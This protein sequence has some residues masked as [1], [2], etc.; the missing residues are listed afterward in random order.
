MTVSRPLRE[1]ILCAMIRINYGTAWDGDLELLKKFFP[2]W[3]YPKLS[4]DGLTH[5]IETF[6]PSVDDITHPG[7]I[8]DEPTLN[9]LNL[10]SKPEDS[11][12]L[13]EHTTDLPES[14]SQG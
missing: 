7:F 8:T 5:L 10:Q 12:S 2:D 4:A 11:I 6:S 1:Q 9:D 14:I 3:Y 13:V